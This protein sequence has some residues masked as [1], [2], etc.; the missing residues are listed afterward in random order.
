MCV[1]MVHQYLEGTNC[2][3]ADEFKTRHQPK[4]T[5]VKLKEVLSKWNEEQLARGM[6]YH[7]L[8][9]VTPS[10][11]LQFRD[12]HYCS[13]DIVPDQLLKLVKEAHQAHQTC[14]NK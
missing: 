9:T 7:H 4:Q 2:D 10:L 6:V 5:N 12:H 8:R 11:A 3:L 1:S 13:L 14:S